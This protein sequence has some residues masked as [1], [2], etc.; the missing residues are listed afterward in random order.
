MHPPSTERVHSQEKKTMTKMVYI[1]F[2]NVLYC[3]IL[4]IKAFQ[5][6]VSYLSSEQE[7][8]SV[9]DIS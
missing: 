5:Q 2:F 9:L 8:V 3:L 7:R 4:Q 6:I 1:N